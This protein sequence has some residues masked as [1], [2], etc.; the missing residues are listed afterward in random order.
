MLGQFSRLKHAFSTRLGG[1]SVA[2]LASFNVGRLLASPAVRQ[3]LMKNRDRFCSALGIS[4]DR[5]VVPD[6]SH[7]NVVLAINSV[8]NER[9]KADGL[10][11]GVANLPIMVTFADCVPILIFDPEKNVFA[12]VHAGWKGT[13]SQIAAEAV[14]LL[15]NHWGSS[16][17]SLVAAVGPAIGS[18]CYPSGSDSVSR[19]LVSITET[20]IGNGNGRA[21][22]DHQNLLEQVSQYELSKFLVLKNDQFHPDLKAINALHLL[23]AGVGEIDISNLC[24]ACKP[25]MFYSHR[26]LGGETGRQGAIA[27]LS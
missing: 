24:T 7:S 8:G 6:M 10:A 14:K 25:E 5:L 2:P 13:A 18:C 26:R 16:P 11:T 4:G 17:Q 23:R 19:L 12:L 3:D 15:Q 9:P 21:I 27:C 20:E 1:E 22:V